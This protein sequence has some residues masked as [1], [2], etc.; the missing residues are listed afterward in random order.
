MDLREDP[1]EEGNIVGD[2]DEILLDKFR[3]YLNQIFLS[4]YAMEHDVFW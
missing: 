4:Q 3:G 2:V 1:M